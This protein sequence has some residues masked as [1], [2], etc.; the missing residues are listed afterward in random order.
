[1]KYAAIYGLILLL[2]T[3]STTNN[4]TIYW[5]NSYR[6][7]CVGVGPMKCLLIQKGEKITEGEW[8][9]FYA[10]IEGFEYEPGFIYK[11]NVKEEQLENVP[12]D[13]SSIKYT[14]VKILE[15][16]E[17]LKFL[18]NGR[19]D[20]V[21][22]ADTV[23]KIPRIRGAGVVPQIQFDLD[24]MQIAGTDGCNNFTGSIQQIGD[25]SIEWGPLASTRKMCVD[26]TIADAFAEAL[27]KVKQ[28]TLDA[29][30]LI[31]SD[32]DGNELLELVKATEAKVLLNDIWVAEWVDGESVS[33]QNTAPRLEINS[34][35]MKAIGNDGCNNFNGKIT[36]LTNTELTFGPI[37]GTRKM[38]PEMSI[39]DKF[40]GA[41]SLTRSYKISNLKLTLLNEQD[42]A[43]MILKKVD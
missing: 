21:K 24:V 25:T 35:T 5:I 26:M 15:K 8:Q 19:W 43:L 12:A 30:K 27:N 31:L 3:C 4:D 34:S 1:M 6:V 14:L 29:N 40:N 39:P 37:A 13:G 22:I 23:I 18:L 32:A 41:L 38:C 17:D 10:K 11:L 16:K 28:Y 42:K 7:D 36:L 20:A 33:D 2:A 9:N